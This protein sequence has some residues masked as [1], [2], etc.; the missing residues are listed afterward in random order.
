VQGYLKTTV[1][2]GELVI[3]KCV[4]AFYVYIYYTK[5]Q[6]VE[7]VFSDLLNQGFRMCAMSTQF[8]YELVDEVLSGL[9]IKR[10]AQL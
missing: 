6:V 2:D 9:S 4:L 8:G 5:S 3:A 10:I 1:A 7:G